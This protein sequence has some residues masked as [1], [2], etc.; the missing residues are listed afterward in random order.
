MQTV[1]FDTDGLVRETD[2]SS[3]RASALVQ[4]LGYEQ[5]RWVSRRGA[6]RDVRFMCTQISSA[7]FANFDRAQK[8]QRDVSRNTPGGGRG[9]VAPPVFKTGLAGN[10]LAG[11]FDS[12]PP[13]PA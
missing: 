5:G 10:T 1:S 2:S 13:P 7:K 3:R 9:P 6:R 4:K 8:P 12:F 11:R